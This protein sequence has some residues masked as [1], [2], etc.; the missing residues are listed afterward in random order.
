MPDR[1]ASAATYTSSVGLVIFGM[2]LSDLA[3]LVGMV[4]GIAT[5]LTNL[6]F[7]R[8]MLKIAQTKGVNI[9]KENE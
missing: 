1:F 5:Y 2:Q 8:Q 3:L 6:Y 4:L 7:K 9:S